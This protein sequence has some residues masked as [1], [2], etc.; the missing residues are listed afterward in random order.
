MKK[1]LLLFVFSAF[2]TLSAWCQK[3]YSTLV[4]ELNDGSRV[5]YVLSQKPTIS[6]VNNAVCITTGDN[7]MEVTYP[8]IEVKRL[9]LEVY[10]PAKDIE[11]IPFPENM[12]KVKYVDGQRVV[13]SGTL[14]SDCISIYNLNGQKL[15]DH[16]ET[17]EGE[18]SVNIASLPQGI[19]MIRV[20]DKQT[21]KILKQ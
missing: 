12:L 17:V 14:P 13:I 1:K 18:T 15:P 9:N 2:V 4:V 19:Y 7:G 21:F 16:V 3:E 20:S 6:M 8:S 5:D 10:D 11:E